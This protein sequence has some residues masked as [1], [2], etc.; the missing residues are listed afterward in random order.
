LDGAG[1]KALRALGKLLTGGLLAPLA[2][3]I[4]PA[5]AQR[6][7]ENAV[8]N[9]DDAFGTTVGL[10]VTG[11]YSE[12]DTR[13]FS[14]LDAGNSRIDGIYFDQV[15][16]LPSRLKAGSSIRVGF[17]AETYPF[18]AP[19][20]IV[21]NR[22][23]PWPTELGASLAATHYPYGGHIFDLDLRMPV[24][25]DRIGLLAGGSVSEVRMSSGARTVASGFV[26]RPIFRFG[27]FE[28][29]PFA[30]VSKFTLQQPNPVVVMSA[31][32]I[33]D[34]PQ[35]GRYFGQPWAKGTSNANNYGATLRGT[36]TDR[37]SLRAGLF[38]SNEHRMTSFSE[39]F[40]VLDQAGNAR[41]RVTAYPD[42]DTHSL[43]GEAQLAYVLNG[44]GWDHRLIAGYRFRDR[45]TESGGADATSPRDVRLGEI[46][47]FPE[48]SFQF[49][50][51]DE[52][53]VR[54]SSLMLGYIG[55]KGGTVINLGLQR[56]RYRADFRSAAQDVSTS[57][58]ESTWLYNA[59]LGFDL[60]RNLSLYA[61]T[62]RGLEDSG[63]APVNAVNANEQLPAT[64]TTQY[65]A[66]LRWK[67][68]KS[69]LVFNVFQITKPYFSFDPAGI[70]RP[71]GRVR[72]RGVEASL[73]GRF[74]D[75]RL[76][77]L[78]GAVLMR[79][80]VSGPA[81][82]AGDIGDKPAGTP[83]VFARIDA[84]YRTDLLGG[85][86]PTLALSY[87]SS[88]AIGAKPLASLGGEQ[89]TLPAK[90]LLDLGLR[91]QFKIGSV[92][93]SYR[94]VVMNVFDTP[95]WRVIAPNTA[96]MG[97]RRRL[98]ATVAADF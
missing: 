16:T 85:V 23:R 24:V 61:A 64:R 70:Y 38:R 78:A 73:T 43:S 20:G 18:A 98:M 90:A 81:V 11:I 52:G 72:H 27:T 91:Q 59:T 2:V 83:A 1:E 77:V 76:N 56:A 42:R 44:E 3:G 40:T 6:A 60:V 9:A 33:P 46:D 45:T 95:N 5:H 51:V 89:L 84:S 62:Q 34:L 28:F 86:T 63:L 41:H 94:I 29:A 32:F 82:D 13:G 57:R 92:A 37:L 4:A 68:G 65:E 93:A 55:R 74:L 87:T 58:A 12:S 17:A 88:Q 31:D 97:D 36:L 19:T 54:Q 30:G 53:R 15:T 96:I 80:R 49:G 25:E 22:L 69:Q 10:E 66:G 47:P 79:P 48:P 35:T 21:D 67:F 39:I 7:T 50:A 75:D 71:S 14:P 8:K 26:L